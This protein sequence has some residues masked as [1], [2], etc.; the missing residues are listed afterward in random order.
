MSDT[1]SYK[2]DPDQPF[3]QDAPQPDEKQTNVAQADG[4]TSAASGPS[5]DQ[6]AGESDG[7]RL[8]RL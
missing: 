6:A 2:T 1:K 4:E 3:D 7:D 5:N 8:N